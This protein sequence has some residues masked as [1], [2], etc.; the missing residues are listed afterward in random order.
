[1]ARRG[2]GSRQ[3]T[4]LLVGSL[5]AALL[6][7]IV[8]A[9]VVL[10]RGPGPKKSGASPGGAAAAKSGDPEVVAGAVAAAKAEPAEIADPVQPLAAAAQVPPAAEKGKA[11]SLPPVS[12]WLDATRQKGGIRD[13]VRLGVGSVWLESPEGRP[14]IL[15]VEVEI[16]NLLKEESLEFTGWRPDDQ[17]QPE[18]RAAMEDDARTVL[19]P[20]SSPAGRRAA[21]RR[22]APGQSEREQLS[23]V[24]P[25]RDAKKL[26]LALPYAAVGRTG[27][28]GFELPSQMIQDQP[29][30]AEPPAAR[31]SGQAPAASAPPAATEPGSAGGEPETIGP[32]RED[33]ERSE[34]AD[35]GMNEPAE[36]A[37][38][39][40]P[41]Q[42]REPEQ[43]P[44]IRKLI[45][46]DEQKRN[47]QPEAPPAEPAAEPQPE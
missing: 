2:R 19:A 41:Q 4:Q 13:V 43:I 36:P 22:I 37:A 38:G 24:L 28:L 8:V 5:V 33:I 44:D 39:E 30:G 11:S 35:A 42:E 45:E 9:V 1:V 14:A 6:L 34:P 7:L 46:Q 12:R 32:M 26:R 25:N 47:P 20:A 16:G 29:P 3:K 15:H 10:N 27:C 40:S 17:P 18:M 31:K 23:F 21:R